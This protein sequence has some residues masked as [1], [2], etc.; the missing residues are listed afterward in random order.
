[1]HDNNAAAHKFSPELAESPIA[2]MTHRS[3]APA[4]PR[5]PFPTWPAMLQRIGRPLRLAVFA[6]VAAAGLLGGTPALAAFSLDTVAARAQALAREPYRAPASTVNKALLDLSYDDYR[7]IRFRPAGSVWRD[8]GLPFELQ[9][10]HVGRGFSHP[11]RLHEVVDG[12][13]Q[14]LAVPRQS[15][16]YGRAAPAVAGARSAEVAGFRVHAALN[17]PAYKDELIV[18]L[19][20]SYFRTVGAGQHYGLSARGLAVDTVGGRGEEFPAF[21]AFWLERPAAGATSLTIHAL[22]NGP[23]VTGAY[24]FVVRPGKTTEVEVQARLYLRGPVATLGLAPLT[25]MFFGGENQPPVGDFRPEVHDS[26]GLQIESGDGEWLWR[27]LVNPQRAFTT[28]FALRGLRGFGL[29]QRDR[30]FASYEDPEARYDRR[31]NVWITPQGD[32]GPGRVELMQFH[33]PDETNDNVVAYW[34]PE[35]LPPV[36]EPLALAYTMRWQG[37]AWQRPPAGWVQQTRSGRSYAD[38]QPG[39][40]QFNIDFAGTALEALADDAAPT[41]RVTPGDN[42][43]VLLANV[44]RHPLTKG[45]RMTLKIQRLDPSR[46]LELRAYLQRGADVLTETWTYALPPT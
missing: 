43:R 44:Y 5:R 24:R 1:M 34:V 10:F 31:P 15:F 26:D 3:V 29:M 35:R 28:S 42:A 39:E 23:R 37:D 33:T 40:L 13:E 14:P 46:P 27:P 20:A 25:S 41:A 4:L 32:W 18:F 12:R 45:W 36:G 6:I 30:A 9:F 38:P 19:G 2:D 16:D 17:N 7:D 11:V 22:L 8:S 21:E